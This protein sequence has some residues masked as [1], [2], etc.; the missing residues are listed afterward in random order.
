L[1]V[2]EIKEYEKYLG[3]PTMVGKNKSASLNFIKERVGK[4]PRVEGKNSISSRQGSPS[5]SGGPSNSYIL[6]VML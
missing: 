5:K 3:L 2:L 6:Y 1:G 4:I